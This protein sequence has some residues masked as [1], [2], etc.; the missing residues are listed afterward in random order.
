MHPAKLTPLWITDLALRRWIEHA[1]VYGDETKEDITKALQDAIPV[2]R[3]EQL[4]FP[5]MDNSLYYRLRRD[6]R[7]HFVIENLLER[8]GQ[9]VLITVVNPSNWHPQWREGYVKPA[10]AAVRDALLA[11]MDANSRG[12]FLNQYASSKS[13]RRAL[14]VLE[15]ARQSHVADLPVVELL[16]ARMN[17]LREFMLG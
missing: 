14:R 1:A 2:T 4:P 12:A 7:V 17:E 3:D 6:E 11:R 16:D 13:V 15:L 5:R 10:P 8:R 9:Y